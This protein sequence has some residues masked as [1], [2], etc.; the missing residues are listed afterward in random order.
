MIQGTKIQR[1]SKEELAARIA[2]HLNLA[3]PHVSSGASVDSRFL[4]D[5]HVA[6][7]GVPTGGADTYRKVEGVLHALGLT[8]DPYWDTSEAAEKGGGTVTTRAYSRILVALTGTPRCFLLNTN[9]APVGA[10]YETDRET[11]Y[12]YDDRVTGRRPLNEAGPGSHVVY[13]STSKSASNPMQFTA[14]AGIEY[15]GPGWTG[16]W[17]ARVVDFRPFQSPVARAELELPGWNHQHAITEITWETY[18][19]IV[20]AGTTGEVATDIDVAGDAGGAEIA[21]RV[22]HDFPPNPGP[23]GRTVIAV[24]K[25]LPVGLLEGGQ[26]ESPVYV[27]ED[28]ALSGPSSPRRSAEDRRR[29]K[30]A[31]ERAVQVATDSLERDGWSL[32]R[33]RQMDGVGY[34]LHFVRQDRQLKVEVKGIQGPRLAFNL[35][36]KE[37][38]R[39][40][41]DEAFV[42]LAVT[43]VLSPDD[44]RVHLV[45]RDLIVSAPRLITGYRVQIA[46]D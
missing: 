19:A 11:S 37:W 45:T 20:D 3:V 25:D 10:K 35:T 42:V 24:P 44:Y 33:D 39:A 1:P 12:G 23:T 18:L 28:G 16:P 5:V 36:P 31:E 8:Y 22:A 27:E 26:P 7:T 32:E 13:Y 17:Q 38:W 40:T 4:D 34:D 2:G 29:D 15:I 9:D 6:L 41:T 30:F 43:S 21:E 46:G 14:H